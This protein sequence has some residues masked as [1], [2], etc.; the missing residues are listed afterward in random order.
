MEEQ[1]VI[2]VRLVDDAGVES[3]AAVYKG[4]TIVPPSKAQELRKE[5]RKTWNKTGDDLVRELDEIL[6][7]ERRIINEWDDALLLSERSLK[8]RV[9]N[10]TYKYKNFK[11]EVIFID[12]TTNPKK[13]IDWNARNVLGSFNPGSPPKLNLRRQVTELTL[14]H[15]I[16][17][18]EDLKKLGKTKYY[19]TPNWKHEESVWEKVWETRD[20][21]TEKEL[22]D[23]Y[24]YYK[25]TAKKETGKFNSIDELDTSLEKP[26][27]KN[28]RCKQ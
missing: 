11:L 13:L 4:E 18:L 7:L 26:Y 6:E 2:F 8:K 22:V 17:H 9:K 27:Y 10:L 28:I 19:E 15:E 20:K 24:R 23:S 21:W 12:E 25:N 1:G 16:W 3:Y 14:Q 5:L